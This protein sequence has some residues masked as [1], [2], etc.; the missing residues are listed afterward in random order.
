MCQY[1]IFTSVAQVTLSSITKLLHYYLD[2]IEVNIET[3]LR[4]SQLFIPAPDIIQVI[5]GVRV[6]LILRLSTVR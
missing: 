2:T 3:F 4:V 1:N 6:K 5:C